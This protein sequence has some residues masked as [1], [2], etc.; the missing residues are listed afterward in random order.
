VS[1]V[2]SKNI[3]VNTTPPDEGNRGRILVD[4]VFQRG[5]VTASSETGASNGWL[6]NAIDGLTYD[7]WQ[8]AALPAWISVE[9]DQAQDVDCGLVA[10]HS[11]ITYSFQ[12]FDGTSWVDLH[13]QVV[14]VDGSVSMPIFE[15]VFGSRLRINVTASALIPAYVG[16]VMLGKSTVLPKQFYS[17]HRPI[18]L[19]RT[20]DLTKNVTEGGFVSGVYH[21]RTGAESSV[22][23]DNVAATWVRNNLADLNK[24][25]ETRPFGFA[26]RPG[27]QPD[28]VAYCWLNSQIAAKNS[29]PRDLMSLTFD[30]SAHIGTPIPPKET[31][32]IFGHT[33]NPKL[34]ISDVEFGQITTAKSGEEPESLV[35]TIRQQKNA[36]FIV[37]SKN[38]TETLGAYVGLYAY[39]NK[40]L[41]NVASISGPWTWHRGCDIHPTGD[42][43]IVS[44]NSVSTA[45]RGLFLYRRI[46]D[47]DDMAW[48]LIK[49]GMFLNGSSQ[50]NSCNGIT[51][52][53]D[54][55]KI[56]WCGN[57]LGIPF[58]KII[59]FS[60]DG[61]MSELQEITGTSGTGADVFWHVRFSDSG[62]YFGVSQ[63]AMG[64]NTRIYGFVDGIAEAVA[65]GRLQMSPSSR[66]ADSI[67]WAGDS[68]VVFGGV[69][70]PFL[71]LYKNT[72]EGFEDL[73]DSISHQPGSEVT[74]CVWNGNVL[75]VATVSHQFL[76][77]DLI[78]DIL[79]R[80]N[81]DISFSG[82]ARTVNKYVEQLKY[83]ALN[84]PNQFY[85]WSKLLEPADVVFS[86]N[87][88]IITR[89]VGANYA[90]I[91]RSAKAWAS[92]KFA[93]RLMLKRIS[94]IYGPI[95]GVSSSLTT[96]SYL[97]SQATGY[98]FYADI[99]SGG[100]E[101]TYNAGVGVD[102]GNIAD[103]TTPQEV[104]IEFD[105][106]GG[107][108]WFGV[109]GAWL[110]GGD[111]STGSTPNYSGMTGDQW[112]LMADLLFAG[113]IELIRPEDFSTPAS[114]GFTPGWPDFVV[115]DE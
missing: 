97:G 59:S 55:T 12:Y 78:D 13:E 31:I 23:I 66:G 45:N 110:T 3:A 57:R 19:N 105:I 104:M 89:N 72:G 11:G 64:K 67:A 86:N 73:T 108:I 48:I 33:L 21:A 54:G 18:T 95:V 62:E 81:G 42:Y 69:S 49:H 30:I 34:T 111:P 79:Q 24:S 20:V 38:E 52:N 40:N 47:G 25:L 100:S 7:W 70:A 35:F 14:A 74:G 17:G 60:D 6:E 37:G 82:T 112:Y 101:R 4:N 80:R 84:S 26:W 107:N 15:K 71:T 61:D 102:F 88:H 50:L 27:A 9:L 68:Y 10:V 93:V 29:G 98:S 53:N 106:D 8:P 103:F 44:G 94:A 16:V 46:S 28:D 87:N 77:Y 85:G 113:E 43:A 56:L 92:G 75:V 36:L 58:I 32:F 22:Q 76:V 41:Q 114:E 63:N 51:F 2:I 109:N 91:V 99:E 115:S 83:S 1:V 65:V 90:R 39:I 96:G 5:T